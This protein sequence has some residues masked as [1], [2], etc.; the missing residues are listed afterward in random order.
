[1]IFDQ[2]DNNDFQLISKT[3]KQLPFC[4]LLHSSIKSI[5]NARIQLLKVAK[6][7]Y[8]VFIDSDDMISDR[9][10]EKIHNSLKINGYPD[11]LLVNYQNC[12]KN[13]KPTIND[14]NVTNDFNA[15]YDEFLYGAQF[16]SM[17]RKIFKTNLFKD[18]DKID[19]S[20]QYGEDW[21]LTYYIFNNSKTIFYD[22]TIFDY[23]YIQSD[24]SITHTADVSK[25]IKMI[26][27]RDRFLPEKLTKKQILLYSRSKIGLYLYSSIFLLKNG[28]SYD[29]FKNFSLEAR[30]S[31]ISIK[32]KKIIRGKLLIS[33]ILLLFLRKKYHAI[34][35]MLKKSAD[36]VF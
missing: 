10:L 1:M 26:T 8:S 3:V 6:G 2:S 19:T 11:V 16:A 35:S 31:Y 12:V 4:T 22:R 15:I 14:V 17:W 28:I 9:Y 13:K 24:A 32:H 7:E 25:A 27:I 36:K 30:E 20:I 29:D 23:Q 5:S 18:F 21:L 33:F 34:Y